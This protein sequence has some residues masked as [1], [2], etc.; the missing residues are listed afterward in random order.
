MLKISWR[1]KIRNDEVLGCAESKN[2]GKMLAKRFI[3]LT[4][5]IL[6]LPKSSK[7]Y[8]ELDIS[9][10]LPFLVF[11]TFGFLRSVFFLDFK[12]DDMKEEI[13]NLKT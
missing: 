12:H 3:Q 4:G 7:G 8:H 9:I 5:H 2:L 11:T 13:K 6:R 10:I 1:D